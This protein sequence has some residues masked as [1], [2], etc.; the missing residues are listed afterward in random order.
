MKTKK[1]FF[2]VT[3]FTLTL[4][5]CSSDQTLTVSDVWARP[6]I[7]G[8][9]SGVF[10]TIDNPS[11]EPDRLLSAESDAADAVELHQTTMVDDVMKMTPQEFVDIPANGQVIF[12]PGDL[13]VMLIGLHNQLN[14]GDSFELIL[15]FE[16]AGEITLTATVQEP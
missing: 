7:A 5:A 8:G 4:T 11:G 1:L 15:T 3:I 10:F 2:L 13:H 6:G 16:N 9:N 14:A 12:Q